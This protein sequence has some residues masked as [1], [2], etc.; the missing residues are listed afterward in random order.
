MPKI[1]DYY[2]SSSLSQGILFIYKLSENFV[3]SL[4]N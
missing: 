3:E 1:D 2:Y 4:T